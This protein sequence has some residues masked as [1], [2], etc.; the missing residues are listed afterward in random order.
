MT[1]S[2]TLRQL[3]LMDYEPVW[4]AMSGYTDERG[5]DSADDAL[6]S[7]ASAGVHPGPSR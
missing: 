2:V 5:Q 1:A 7:A 6:G 3:G 4:K